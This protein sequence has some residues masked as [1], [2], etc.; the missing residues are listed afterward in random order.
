MKPIF[1]FPATNLV[2]LA[3]LSAVIYMI[4]RVFGVHVAGGGLSNLLVFAFGGSLIS[5]ALSK[6]TAKRMMGVR[7]I[8]APQSDL[9]NRLI[10]T[11]R[12]LAEQA[13]V[14]MPKVGVFEAT[15]INAFATGAQ[16]TGQC[17]PG[18]CEHRPAAQHA[19]RPERSGT[20][21]RNH[22]CDER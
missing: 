8:A 21:S 16:G 2:V 4:E 15:Q 12:R 13:S 9:K 22:P 6:S 1:L 14:S 3:L 19:A 5:L 7:A 11:V 18:G 10:D 17:A 20:G